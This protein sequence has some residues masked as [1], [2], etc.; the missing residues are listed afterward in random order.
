MADLLTVSQVINRSKGS[1]M[2]GDTL[3]I[4]G[5]P[6]KA[7]GNC[8]KP[9]KQ[10]GDNAHIKVVNGRKSR[11]AQGYKI[12]MGL[13]HDVEEYSINP[14]GLLVVE[15]KRRARLWQVPGCFD[16]WN[17]QDQAK[18]DKIVIEARGGKVSLVFYDVRGR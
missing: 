18:R 1:V 4:D 8:E 13:Y 16:C 3:F 2:I 10:Y 17:F 12:T 14:D 9:I 11:E 7:C 5:S 6:Y 15:V